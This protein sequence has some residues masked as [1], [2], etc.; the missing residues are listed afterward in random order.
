MQAASGAECTMTRESCTKGHEQPDLNNKN[1]EKITFSHKIPEVRSYPAHLLFTFAPDLR[2]IAGKATVLWDHG[3]IRTSCSS[4]GC[5]LRARR[6]PPARIVKR[7][8]MKPHAVG[9]HTHGDL[10]H[11]AF[12][13]IV[14]EKES[15]ARG[16]RRPENPCPHRQGQG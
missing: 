8:R 12:F 11:Q 13:Q 15:D 7:K 1:H 2:Q 5:L 10:N 16:R 14:D 4:K 9:N 6:E 3:T